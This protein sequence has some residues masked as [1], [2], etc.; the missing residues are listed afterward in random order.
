ML[1]I[2]CVFGAALKKVLL[3]VCSY[4]MYYLLVPDHLQLSCIIQKP[5]DANQQN[6]VALFAHMTYHMFHTKEVLA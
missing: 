3:L 2:M 1:S 4:Q 6:Q 5:Y